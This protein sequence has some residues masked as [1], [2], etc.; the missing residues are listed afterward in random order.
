MLLVILLIG[1][2]IADYFLQTSD[3]AESKKNN[4]SVLLA[5]SGMYF[6]TFIIIDFLFF[7]LWFAVCTT[8]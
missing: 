8:A 2:M 7:E 6:L 4:V 5:H 3:M 1:H